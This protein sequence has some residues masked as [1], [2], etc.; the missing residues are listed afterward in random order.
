MP[1]FRSFQRRI[2]KI[3][4]TAA[5]LGVDERTLRRWIVER[6]E[7]RPVLRAYRHGKQ[8]RLNVPKTWAEFEQYRW[9]VER[10]I[11]L[12]HRR[13]KKRWKHS[14]PGKEIATKLGFRDKQR[15]RDLLI[16]RAATELK[17]AD[18]KPTSVFKAK[19]KLAAETRT[20][21]SSESV[22]LA[23]IISAKYRCPVFDVPKYLDRWIAEESTRERKNAA[24]RIRQSWPTTTQWNK[25]SN[26]WKSQWLQ[27]TLIEAA[28]ECIDLGRRISGP[29]LA[30]LLF[31]NP[32]REHAWKANDKLKQQHPSDHVLLDPYGK[33]GT[34]LRLFRQRYDRK[35]IEKVKR[36]AEGGTQSEQLD[37]SQKVSDWLK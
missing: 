28:R 22:F 35:D 36:V 23:R 37:R 9:A 32:H 19:S 14:T 11:S 4:V 16:L 13:R 5:E 1:A 8:W 25:A 30:P 12:F 7:L 21:R 6:P 17:I 18:T 34:S 15:E 27:R 26:L 33:R 31:Q 29:N 10:A 2:D 20:N 24:R 3:R